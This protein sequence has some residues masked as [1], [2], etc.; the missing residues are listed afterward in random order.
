M[1][2]PICYDKLAVPRQSYGCF[3]PNR[4]SELY[5]GEKR[6][7]SAEI[8]TWRALWNPNPG[9]NWRGSGKVSSISCYRIDVR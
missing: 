8:V 6:D 9:L 5:V 7:F 1:A 3:C 4:E 2:G